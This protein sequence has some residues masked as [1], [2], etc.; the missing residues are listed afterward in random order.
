MGLNTTKILI[1]THLLTLWQHFLFFLGEKR[2]TQKA[3]VQLLFWI[4][5][6]YS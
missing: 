6:H 3:G 2:Q 4:C 1:N 5:L